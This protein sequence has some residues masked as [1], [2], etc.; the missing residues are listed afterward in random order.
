MFDFNENKYEKLFE[1][2]S[3]KKTKNE[4][5]EECEKILSYVCNHKN[6]HKEET[7]EYIFCREYLRFNNITFPINYSSNKVFLQEEHTGIVWFLIYKKNN[8]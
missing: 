3:T 8:I 4:K 7:V 6:N 2:L 5:L 1:K